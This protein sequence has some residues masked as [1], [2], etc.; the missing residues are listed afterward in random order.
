M[1]PS[2]VAFALPVVMF[3]I[4]WGLFYMPLAGLVR[5]LKM[6]AKS[7]SAWIARSRVGKWAIGHSGP[8]GPYAPVLLV[9]LLGGVAAIGSGYL[10]VQLAEQ[11]P[12]ATSAVN[13]SDLA[14][15][16]W[17]GNERASAITALFRAA[18]TLGSTIGLAAMAAVVAVILLFR[19]ERA[20]AVFV[21]VT[22]AGGGILNFGL[23][24]IFARA[25]PDLV[26]AIAA[27]RW[28][29]FPSGHAMGSFITFGALAYIALR[30][31]WRWGLK[32]ACLAIAQTIV[33][34]VG[35]SRVYLGVHWASDIAGAWSAG[36]VWLASAVVAFEMLLRLRQ[37]RRG[38]APTSPVFDVTDKPVV[39]SKNSIPAHMDDPPGQAGSGSRNKN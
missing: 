38:A 26:S 36:T 29:S 34:L 12:L 28:F 21:M 5:V 9:V 30:Q 18:T 6:G 39:P 32:S 7:G 14:I 4:F 3:L 35:L 23:K 13:S 19:K 24:M 20:S 8:L 16:T 17:F 22:A 27:A 37:R 31:H 33:I 1:P 10:F 25:R 2:L 15:H 11:I